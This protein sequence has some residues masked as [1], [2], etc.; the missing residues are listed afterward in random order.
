MPAHS[1]GAVAAGSSFGGHA[2][3]EV[4]VD[5][6]PL[7]VAAVSHR[8]GLVRVG[9]VVGE[10]RAARVAVLLEPFPAARARAARSH[11]AADGRQVAGLEPGHVG[12]DLGDAADDLVAGHA[13][14]DGRP[15]RPLVAGGVQVGVAHA[16]VEDVDLD[17]ALAGITARDARRSER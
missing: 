14:I 11:H 4:L 15:R 17:V 9:R 6:D 3:D 10:D 2:Q 1:S 5:D 7:R 13:R 12:A 16:A 8:R